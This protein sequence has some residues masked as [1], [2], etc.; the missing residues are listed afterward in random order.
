MRFAAEN[1]RPNSIVAF[2]DISFSFPIQL[3]RALNKRGYS[4]HNTNPKTMNNLR[5]RKFTALSLA[6]TFGLFAVPASAQTASTD[7]K[8]EPTKLET[9]TVTGSYIPTTETAFSA[10]ASPVVRIDKKIIDESGLTTTAELLQKITVSNGGSVPISNNATG[11]TPAATAISLRGLGPE[12][13]LVLINGRRVAPYPVGAG[14]TTA[15]VDLN[16]IPLS[17]VESIEILKDGASAI[18]G[19]DAVAGVVNIK[20]RRG[21]DGTEV[22]LSYG[23]TT[24]KDSTEFT[25]ALITG[26]QT[27]KASAL[28]GFNYYKKNAIMNADRSY[29][30]IPP[31]LSSNASPLNLQISRAAALEAGVPAGSLPSTGSSFYAKSPATTSN[32]GTTPATGFTYTSGR[33]STF[34]FNEYSMSYP[35]RDNRGVFAY[36]ERKVFDTDNIKVY[37]DTAYQ[38]AVTE[39]QLAPSATGNFS[40]SG[41]ELVIPARTATP[42]PTVD[43]RAR[44]AVAGA[45]NP[46]NP[47]NIDITGG[48]RARLAEFGNRI[49][50][51]NTDAALITT[52]IKG[53]NVAEKWN[54]DAGYSYSSIRDTSRNTLVSS[55]RFNRLLNA[56]DSFFNPT[57]PDYLGTTQP[58]NPFGYYKVSIPN[59]AKIVG[60]A[61]ITTKDVNESKINTFNFVISTGSLVDLPAGGVG[62]AFGADARHEELNQYPDPYAATGDL[63]GS[64]PTATTQGQRKV[65]GAFTEGNIPLVKNAPGA[66]DLTATVA[67]RHES[68]VSSG[69]TTNVPKIGLRWQPIDQT[70]TLRGSWS[71][72]FRQPSLYELFSSPTSGLTPIRN[73]ISHAFEPEQD[74]TI[75]GNR[76]LKAEKTKYLNLGFVWS[77]EGA[78]LK[79][80]TF[81]IDYWRAD[82][83]GTVSGNY[84]NT[85]DR[86]F[87]R[88]NSGTAV[89]GGLLPGESVV[90]FSDGSIR[91]VNSVFFNVGKT[92][93]YGYDINVDYALKTDTSGRFNFSTVWSKLESYKQSSVPGAPLV[94]LVNHDTGAGTGGDDGYLK[95]KGRVQVEWAYQGLT[96]VFGTNYTAGFEDLD[97]NGDP[98]QIK[99]TLIYDL[100]IGYNFRDTAGFMLKDTKLTVG[101]RNLFDKNPPYAAGGGG[102]STGYPDY[103]YNSEGRFVY[104]SL[105]R[106]F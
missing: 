104:L 59:N 16:S 8:D 67:L 80:L 20:M 69:E 70:L 106:K 34:N 35:R 44:A 15:F 11:F 83:N 53:E 92:E 90:L 76:R 51:N 52:G 74:V 58:Y 24:N 1:G 102:N 17:A 79:G 5:L 71:K 68:Y 41:T 81:G 27:E 75:S 37:L 88:D 72:G 49:F 21:I 46:F 25:A 39:N 95:W 94:Q 105:G 19:A 13:T 82:R 26:A 86:Y 57:S 48:T 9:F 101:V 84:Q 93:A 28:V 98:F 32:V 96:A 77:P 23:N 29:S 33:T 97:L 73:P 103:L 91:T 89:P 2:R 10:G 12:A 7:K 62:F 38:N 4:V 36:A 6:A 66:H 56:N 85:V 100:Q 99:S 65:W 55:S 54:F 45:Y 47:F 30:A 61:K 31:F 78:G 63:I 42:L 22:M 18:Y 40:G 50:R 14:G 43:G 87:G 64:S 3:N 60:A